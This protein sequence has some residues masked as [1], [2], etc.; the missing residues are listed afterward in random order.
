MIEKAR[1]LFDILMGDLCVLAHK[2][3]SL[4]WMNCK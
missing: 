1:E 3:S 2:L 4:Y